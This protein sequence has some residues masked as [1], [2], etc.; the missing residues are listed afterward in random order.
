MV[1][2]PYLVFQEQHVD[3][4]CQLQEDLR[5][6]DPIK[7]EQKK[8]VL[9]KNGTNNKSKGIYFLILFQQKETSIV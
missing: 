7:K 9:I 2:K 3:L 5:Q 8:K 6:L 4:V 1:G